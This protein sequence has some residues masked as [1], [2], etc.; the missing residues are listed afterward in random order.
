[1]MKN[2]ACGNFNGT[3]EDIKEAYQTFGKDGNGKLS[4][5]EMNEA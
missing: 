2:G 4:Y 5:D 1:M 3:I